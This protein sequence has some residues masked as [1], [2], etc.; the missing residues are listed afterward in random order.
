MLTVMY[1]SRLEQA[2]QLARKSRGELARH[3][4][5]SSQAIGQVISGATKSLTAENSTRAARILRVDHHW[6]ATGEGEPRAAPV[7]SPL[8]LDIARM[9]DQAPAS[10]RDRLYAL[11]SYTLSLAT[12]PRPAKAPADAPAT[13]GRDRGP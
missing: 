5:V 10:E 7:F 9:F 1:G 4:G 2:L 3:L 11:I 12:A 6:L 8:A 13:A